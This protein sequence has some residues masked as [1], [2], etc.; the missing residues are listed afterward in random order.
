MVRSFSKFLTQLQ[1][2]QFS[3]EKI[4]HYKASPYA[5]FF[6]WTTS[7]DKILT[8]EHLQKCGVIILNWCFM[9]KKSEEIADNILLHYE[10]ARVL[11]I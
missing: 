1:N 4:W 10:I 9:Y 6:A 8:T 7:L 11:W 2:I 5:T 3:W